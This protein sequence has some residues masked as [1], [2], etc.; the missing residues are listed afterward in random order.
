M[1]HMCNFIALL[2]LISTHHVHTSTAYTTPEPVLRQ[3]VV[4]KHQLEIVKLKT[5]TIAESIFLPT[6]LA[7]MIADFAPDIPPQWIG[8]IDEIDPRYQYINAI[9]NCDPEGLLTD[10]CMQDFQLIEINDQGLEA[11]QLE[12]A[13]NADWF[14]DI[15]SRCIRPNYNELLECIIKKMEQPRIGLVENSWSS[16]I[17]T[18]KYSTSY[19]T[20]H[21]LGYLL[22]NYT[23]QLVARD[24]ELYQRAINRSTC[25]LGSNTTWSD[26]GEHMGLM[27][28]KLNSYKTMDQEYSF[29]RRWAIPY[30]EA[31]E[32]SPI[33]RLLKEI[34]MDSNLAP[35]LYRIHSSYVPNKKKRKRD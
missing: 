1:R 16:A 35:V 31:Y 23:L 13:C 12:I 14:D 33:P 8:I 2:T 7:R 18:G 19:H 25:L 34:P 28:E 15:T 26:V 5:K 6:V 20:M 32:K 10:P 21:I 29:F 27:H 24:S 3:E 4:A 22:K 17:S 11:A 9:N 30:M